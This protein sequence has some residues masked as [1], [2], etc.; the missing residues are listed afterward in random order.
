M[1][2]SELW[3]VCLDD[4]RGRDAYDEKRK[5]YNEKRDDY[6]EKRKDYDEKR[7]IDRKDYQIFL[8]YY[9]KNDYIVNGKRSINDPRG[10][11]SVVLQN[12]NPTFIYIKGTNKS[13][14]PC[15]TIY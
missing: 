8:G 5:D 1:M 15:T 9:R 12:T 10:N 14:N 7:K 11:A 3:L 2:S 13:F 6:D 4:L